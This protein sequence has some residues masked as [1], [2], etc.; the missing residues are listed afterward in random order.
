MLKLKIKME[1]QYIINAYMN[2]I[3]FGQLTYLLSLI[4]YPLTI[5]I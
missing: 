1:Y 4:T 5:L 3:K 2:K